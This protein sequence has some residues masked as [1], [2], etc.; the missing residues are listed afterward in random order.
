M[1]KTH[2]LL[3]PVAIVCCGAQAGDGKNGWDWGLGMEK[4]NGTG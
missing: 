3:L 2:A 1:L 4:A